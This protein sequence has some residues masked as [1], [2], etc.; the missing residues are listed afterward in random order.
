[1]IKARYG[2]S[3]SFSICSTEKTYGVYFA[4]VLTPVFLL[5]GIYL[6]CALHDKEFERFLSIKEQ[7]IQKKKQ[8]R[9][10]NVGGF[11]E[12]YGEIELLNESKIQNDDDNFETRE[13]LKIDLGSDV[14]KYYED[15]ED[16]KLDDNEVE[17]NRMR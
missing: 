14:S 6:Y 4:I 2:N 10:N 3:K 8:S 15:S 13:R 11:A 9:G 5:F 17:N 7:E 16:E 12:D 1:M